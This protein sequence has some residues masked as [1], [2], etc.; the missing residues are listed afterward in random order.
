MLDIS[1]Y[2]HKFGTFLQYID[3]NFYNV[4]INSDYDVHII[5]ITWGLFAPHCNSCVMY[6]IAILSF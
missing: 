4:T 6:V 3:S 2:C 1:L 5:Q